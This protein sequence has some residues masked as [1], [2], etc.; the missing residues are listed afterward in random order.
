MKNGNYSK[1]RHCKC[2]K[3]ISNK[4]INCSECF[5]KECSK[6]M[7]GHRPWNKDLKNIYSKT[8]LKKMSQSHQGKSPWN[9]GIPRSKSTKKKISEAR[10]GKY[11]GKDNPNYG[12]HKL[13]GENHPNWKDGVSFEPYPISWTKTLKKAIRER[14]NH[15]C[16]ICGKSTKK[17]GRRLDVHH[18]DYDKN[19]L[20]PENLISLCKSCHMKS[21]YNRETY[22]EFFKILKEILK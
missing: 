14:D 13:A 17:N 21:N 3:L 6:R 11:K 18:I 9:S 20:Y 19:N 22:I 1:N 7:K 12:N 2:G 15:R 4:A 8:A 5:G 16:Q 10:K